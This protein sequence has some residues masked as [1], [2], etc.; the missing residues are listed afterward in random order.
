MALILQL[1]CN[2]PPIG[3]IG[4]PYNHTF[5]L[6]GGVPPYTFVLSPP[7]G[8]PPGLLLNTVTGVVSGTPTLQ[9][10][11]PFFLFAVD[12]LGNSAP[13]VQC[14][15]PITFTL[16]TAPFGGRPYQVGPPITCKPKNEYDRCLELEWPLLLRIRAKRPCSVPE[17]LW[18]V[19]PWEADFGSLPALAVPFKS[20][21]SIPTPLAS[22]GDVLVTRVIVPTGYDGL[23]SAIFWRYNGINFV[24]GSGDIFWR[25]RANQRYVKDLGNVGFTLGSS[26]TPLPM[27]EGQQL[28]SGQAVSILVNVPNVSGGIQTGGGST[29]SGGLIGFFW[30]KGTPGWTSR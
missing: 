17:D 2:S 7:T 4:T 16:A 9:G 26:A 24:E 22:A 19:L 14:L 28:Q 12:S 11:Y 29:V 30:P 21:H 3:T 1:S 10:N 18:T 25:V 13:F 20:I 27:T 15:I 5:T 8:L 23:L 6:T